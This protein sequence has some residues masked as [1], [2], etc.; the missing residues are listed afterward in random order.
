[1]KFSERM[2]EMTPENIVRLHAI[3][4]LA[5]VFI[6]PARCRYLTAAVLA[7]AISN[8][9]VFELVQQAATDRIPDHGA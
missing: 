2:I 9:E 7:R 4:Q 6:D 5:A 3:E 8:Q 1:M